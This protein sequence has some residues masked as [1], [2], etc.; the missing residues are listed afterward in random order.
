MVIVVLVLADQYGLIGILITI[1]AVI[2]ILAG[3]FVAVEQV[4]FKLRNL[5]A[6]FRGGWSPFKAP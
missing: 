1:A 3:E 4:P 5:S 6:S 2:Q